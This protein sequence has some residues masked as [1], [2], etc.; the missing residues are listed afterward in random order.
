M[1]WQPLFVAAACSA[2]LATAPALAQPSIPAGPYGDNDSIASLRTYDQLMSA[3]RS[4]A[5]TASRVYR[6]P[7]THS[8]MC[9]PWLTAW[10]WPTSFVWKN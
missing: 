9:K 4:S 10:K 5:Q 7:P 2:V 6:R 8:R 1:K 3:L